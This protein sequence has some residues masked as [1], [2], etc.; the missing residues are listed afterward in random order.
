MMFMG[1]FDFKKF[2]IAA[3]A[4][5]CLSSFCPAHGNSQTEAERRLQASTTSA[6]QTAFCGT[7][8]GNR[9][10]TPG[11]MSFVYHEICR[12]SARDRVAGREFCIDIFKGTTG[13]N[14]NVQ[15]MQA[16]GIAKEYALVKHGLQVEC[17]DQHRTAWNDDFVK[18]TGRDANGRM[19]FFE[20]QFDDIKESV[21][22]Q[23]QRSVARAV[24]TG[25][26]E[27]SFDAGNC[28]LRGPQTNCLM[29]TCRADQATCNRINAS[30]QRFGFSA[31]MQA[32]GTMAHCTIDY[33]NIVVARGEAVDDHLRNPF[34]PHI[35]SRRFYAWK[36]I[37]IKASA[38]LH[39]Q[40]ERYV[41]TELERS[42]TRVTSF[43]CNDGVTRIIHRERR[44]VGFRETDDILTCQVN[45]Q[46]VDFLLDDASELFRRTDRAGQSGI[47]CITSGGTFD[48]RGCRG[49]TREECTRIGDELRK[50]VQGARG[51]EWREV[52]IGSGRHQTCV[53][54]DSEQNARIDAGLRVAGQVA[55]VG[56]SVVATP[57][58][59]GSSLLF[60]IAAVGAGVAAVGT[61]GTIYSENFINNEVRTWI[62]EAERCE[63]I[64]RS[65]TIG[66]AAAIA[67]AERNASRCAEGLLDSSIRR[68]TNLQHSLEGAAVTAVDEMFARLVDLLILE[69]SPTLQTLSR[70]VDEEANRNLQDWEREPIQRLYL[71]SQIAQ[72]TG[73]GMSIGSSLAANLPRLFN[74]ATRAAAN[75]PKITR[76]ATQL[77]RKLET[78][79]KTRGLTAVGRVS[80]GDSIGTVVGGSIDIFGTPHPG[81]IGRGVSQ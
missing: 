32:R 62:L 54:L 3:I 70:L 9:C 1:K 5:L 66:N 42:G 25:I 10:D 78:I 65:A 13:L 57:F 16:H 24:C 74:N 27:V 53:L 71:A 17:C 46:E 55:L 72:I 36:D 73:A 40:V 76:T 50:S 39:T 75:A 30:L 19:I 51:T 47:E 45:G 29:P 67:T 20:F 2:L 48:G 43:R 4:C 60:A 37:Q 59:G 44:T 23:I 79:Q 61:V 68:I 14:T 81:P 64:K 49:L 41:R 69:E 18:C 31:S 34:R 58:T 35:D 6:C 22:A 21:D 77:L 26:H 11:G 33:G 8:I 56:V 7:M 15:A 80:A 63:R 38:E 12:K 52:A 28:N